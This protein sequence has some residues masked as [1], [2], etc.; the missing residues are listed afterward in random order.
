MISLV[1]LILEN[2]KKSQ[3]FDYGCVMLY[4][5]FPQLA[6][7]QSQIE[8]EDLFVP[9]EGDTRTYGKETEPHCTLLYGLHKEVTLDQV[10]EA[11]SDV[12]FTECKLYNVSKFDN[13]KYDVLKF[14]V[15]GNAPTSCGLREANDALKAYPYTSD[16]PDYHPHST[17]A[18]LKKGSAD[19]YISNLKDKEYNLTPEY[20]IYSVPSGD[21]HKIKINVK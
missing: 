16:F 2:D 11:L 5:S 18:Y 9:E 6:E 14:D 12:T 15:K 10:K 17:I 8:D 13:P 19:K 1:K 20:A 7:L 3:K 4:F 21:K